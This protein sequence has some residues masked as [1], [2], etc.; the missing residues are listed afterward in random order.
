MILENP[1]F[2]VGARF[3][4]MIIKSNLTNGVFKVFAEIALREK[5]LTN[6]TK[7]FNH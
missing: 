4:A 1:P 6:F 3:S 2:R 5:V 7:E